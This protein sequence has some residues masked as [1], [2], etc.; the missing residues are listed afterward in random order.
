[1][2]QKQIN[3]FYLMAKKASSFSDYP[4]INIGSI[5]VY[6]N[7]VVSVGWNTK[8]GNPI[9]KKYNKL[10][11]IDENF[12]KMPHSLHSEMCCLHKADNLDIDF[13]KSYLFIYRED[14][15]GKLA[16]CKPCA[17]C[18][19]AIKSKGIKNVFYTM[20]NKFVHELYII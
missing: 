1:M 18:E 15:N 6:K 2:T 12:D 20:P 9:Q 13:N 8:K 4:K 7:K 14:R 5:L 11:D 3:K 16:N 10:R 19:A 17:A